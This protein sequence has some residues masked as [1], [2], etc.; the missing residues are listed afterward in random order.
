M[1]TLTNFMLPGL[2]KIIL[3]WFRMKKTLTNAIAGAFDYVDPPD[4]VTE[5]D[6]SAGMSCVT[7]KSPQAGSIE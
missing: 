5:I 4:P 3:V 2:R 6:Q 1:S 7:T